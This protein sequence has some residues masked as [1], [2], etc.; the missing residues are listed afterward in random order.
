MPFDGK[1]SLVILNESGAIKNI[2]AE[3][4]VFQKGNV[5]IHKTNLQKVKGN[6]ILIIDGAIAG[7][8]EL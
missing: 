1:A 6:A 8:M 2:I 4:Q 5:K 3:N 7:R